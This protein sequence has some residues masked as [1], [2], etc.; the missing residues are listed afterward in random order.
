[1]APAGNLRIRDQ[2]W[3]AQW[4]YGSRT[5]GQP[6]FFGFLESHELRD[7]WPED[8]KVQHTDAWSSPWRMLGMQGE[9]ERKV[10]CRSNMSAPSNLLCWG[11]A[12][13][14]ATV[15]LPTPPLP[16]ATARTFLTLGSGLLCIGPP[17]RGI[18]GGGPGRL[19]RPY[20]G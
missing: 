10:D 4:G 13:L 1:M 12:G 14:P 2:L 6:G 8:V 9:R 16:L 11:G 7:G 3:E 20:M 15:L 19:G 18:C 5:F 17:L